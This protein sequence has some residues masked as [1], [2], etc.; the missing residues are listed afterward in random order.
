MFEPKITEHPTDVTVGRNQPVTLNCQASGSPDPSITWYKNGVPVTGIRDQEPH[1]VLL[2][3]GSLFFLRVRKEQ[4]AGVYHCEARNS[5]GSAR[6][7]DATLSVAG[8]FFVELTKFM[9]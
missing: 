3:S 4:D 2:P 7:H 9:P 5:A 1:R 8:I 6:S